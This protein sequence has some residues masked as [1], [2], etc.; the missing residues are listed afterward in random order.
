MTHGERSDE[1]TAGAATDD[2]LAR[3]GQRIRHLRKLSGM[4]VQELADLSSVSRRLLTQVELGQAN[5][6]LVTVDRIARVLGTDFAGL[7]TD[8]ARD[9]DIVSVHPPGSESL[10]WSSAAG[11]RA[12]LLVATETRG[13]AE[14]WRWML[15]PGDVYP[16]SPDPAGSEELFQV[17]SGTLTITTVDAPD[18][19]VIAGGS[20]R[21]KSDRK[22]AYENRGAEEVTFTRVVV[23]TVH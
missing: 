13:G 20:A 2:F 4:T 6:S 1:V 5:P 11:S 12:W 21:L 22:Y 17:H 18:A 8:L 9:A 19:T 14:L 16:A 7:S 15:T 23:V 10:I 3:V